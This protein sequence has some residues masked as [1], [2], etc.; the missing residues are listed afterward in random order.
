MSKDPFLQLDELLEKKI[1]PE[2]FYKILKEFFESYKAELGIHGFPLEKQMPIL[3][4][5]LSLNQEQLQTPYPFQPFHQ[6]IVAPFDYYTF[7]VE[8]LRPLVDTQLSSA[9]A[10]HYA[11]E[12]CAYLKK[13]HNAILFA[14]HQIEADPQAISLLLEKT[15]PELAKKMIF[16]AGDRV[17]TDP[18]A[19]PFSLGRNLLC[20]YSK[21]YIDHPP[22]QKLKKQL[23]NKKTME[24]MRELLSEG[25]KAIYVAPS[26]GRDRANEKGVVEVALFDP[27]SVE[28]FYLMSQR[29]HSPTHFYTLALSTYDLIPPP[30]TVQLE[31]GEAR[32]TKRGAIHLAFGPEIDMQNIPESEQK[33]KHLKRE[34]RAN[35][36]WEQVKKD[37]SKF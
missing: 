16:V 27:Q 19:V 34:L 9:R 11:D 28:M 37:Y 5:Y 32:Q 7:G 23:H 4:T 14:N 24:V 29:A 30:E 10:L 18:L 3:D 15:H 13:G 20:I 2:K 17:V 33:D 31:L 21:R 25:G 8:F 26:G 36:I 22:E 35:Y 6:Q 12:I 1:I